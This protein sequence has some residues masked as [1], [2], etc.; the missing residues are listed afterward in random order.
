MGG[1]LENPARPR[2][3]DH[4]VMQLASE[5]DTIL[6]V[7]KTDTRKRFRVSRQTL[8][9]ASLYNRQEMLHVASECSEK[10]CGLPL[11]A[12]LA[13]AKQTE[14]GFAVNL[15]QA[16]PE[17]TEVI[18]SVLHNE[19]WRCK[20][21]EPEQLFMV[22]QES[23]QNGFDLALQASISQW[24]GNMRELESIEE[25]GLLRSAAKMFG[26]DE[27]FE[28]RYDCIAARRSILRGFEE[29]WRECGTKGLSMKIESRFGS[30]TV[31][32]KRF[33]T[34]YSSVVKPEKRMDAADIYHEVHCVDHYLLDASD[35]YE[36]DFLICSSCKRLHDLEARLCGDCKQNGLRRQMCTKETRI[37]EYHELLW[38]KK[39][40]PAKGGFKECTAAQLASRICQLRDTMKHECGG[41]LNCPLL[42][43]VKKLHG[44]VEQILQGICKLDT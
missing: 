15:E 42:M 37:T 35:E 16:A 22:A 36:M 14:K 24:F 2:D 30:E 21:L 25:E 18:L 9:D 31:S 32:R 28:K 17:I 41:G 23:Q 6:V 12:A 43:G 7:G 20:N 13:V 8:L 11:V 5:G 19:S 1:N 10:G 4:D 3:T 38:S 33:D 40:L 44:D 27:Y 26:V 39:I 29:F 34:N